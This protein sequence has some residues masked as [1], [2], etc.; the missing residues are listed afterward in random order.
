MLENNI[1]KPMPGSEWMANI[2]LVRKKDGY[3]R[4]CVDYRGLNA[5]TLKKNYPLPMV[6]I[7]LESLGNNC[8]YFS[9]DMRAGYWQVH[10][11]VEDI[12]KT[13]LVT[14]KGVFGFRVLPFGL[15]NAPSTFQRLVTWHLQG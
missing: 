14:R 3:L 15:C 6:D 13:C 1:I 5:V 10:M 8:L 7:C 2:V 9:L 4:Y 12:E 11:K